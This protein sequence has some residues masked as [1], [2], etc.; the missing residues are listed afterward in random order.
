M[1]SYK[2]QYDEKQQDLTHICECLRKKIKIL[3]QTLRLSKI[4]LIQKKETKCMKVLW[5]KI[6]RVFFLFIMIMFKTYY[7]L[8]YEYN[9]SPFITIW[10]CLCIFFILIHI[11]HY[12][13]YRKIRYSITKINTTKWI[14]NCKKQPLSNEVSVVMG[15][16]TRLV[17]FDFWI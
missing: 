16:D 7:F 9:I 2:W 5:E 14:L 1:W 11:K 6:Q 15:W 13:N 17:S 10:S 12:Q 8:S 4:E 3:Y